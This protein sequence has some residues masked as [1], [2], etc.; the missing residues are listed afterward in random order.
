[1]GL[2]ACAWLESRSGFAEP[3]G[4]PGEIALGGRRGGCAASP[5]GRTNSVPASRCQL[6]PPNRLALPDERSPPSRTATPVCTLVGR[7]QPSHSPQRRTLLPQ[8]HRELPSPFP[9]PCPRTPQVGRSCWSC[10]P[11]RA[12]PPQ[13]IAKPAPIAT[14]RRGVRTMRSSGGSQRAP[15]CSRPCQRISAAMSA[16]WRTVAEG[17]LP[18]LAPWLPLDPVSQGAW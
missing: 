8:L 4:W 7:L 6:P 18:C 3:F 14:P 17:A 15:K 13:P 12:R 2:A 9:Q 16:C 1:V 5:S 11:A 10:A